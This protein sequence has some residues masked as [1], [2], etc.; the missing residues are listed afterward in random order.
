MGKPSAPKFA[1]NKNILVIGG[2][3]SGKTRFFVKPNLMQMHSSYVVTDPKG[4]VLVE[5][6]KLIARG[7]PAEEIAYIHDAKTEQQKADLFDKVRSGEIRVLLGSTAKMGTGTNVQKKLIAVHDL[8][9]PWRPADVEHSKRNIEKHN[10]TSR[11]ILN[12]YA[13]N[14]ITNADFTLFFNTAAYPPTPGRYTAVLFH[15]S[16]SLTIP[17]QYY[18]I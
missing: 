12:K 8:D 6:G 18:I 14:Q 4:T 3:G 7:I 5:C 11:N 10:R 13:Q 2:S 9:I 16:F 15:R 17:P 1:R